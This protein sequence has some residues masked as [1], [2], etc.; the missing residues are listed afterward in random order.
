V[1]PRVNLIE[2]MLGRTMLCRKCHAWLL[3]D[4]AVEKHAYTSQT[5]GEC[6]RHAGPEDLERGLWLTTTIRSDLLL[7]DVPLP[8]DVPRLQALD[9]LVVAPMQTCYSADCQ[10]PAGRNLYP[11]AIVPS[12]PCVRRRRVTISTGIPIA[13]SV[14]ATSVSWAV[15]I[16]PSS[17]RTSATV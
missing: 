14:G 17:R 1:T 4:N 11:Y 8:G 13:T 2:P 6:P 16:G 9:G 15:T 5:Q 3:R 10:N 12:S 7:L